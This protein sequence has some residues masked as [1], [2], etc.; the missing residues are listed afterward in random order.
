MDLLD[1]SDLADTLRIINNVDIFSG[2]GLNEQ[3]LLARKLREVHYLA[4]EIVIEQGDVGDQLYIVLTGKVD[5]SI[6]NKDVPRVSIA[7]LGPGD[8][9]G[10]IAILRSIPRTARIT[11]LEPCTFLTINAQDFLSIYQ[12]FP[13]QARD[14]MQLFIAKRLQN[15]HHRYEL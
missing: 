5:V 1:N 10:E 4:D 2:I 15:K 3:H 11:T 7:T 9:F 12:Y 13:K 14:N 6:K 8:V